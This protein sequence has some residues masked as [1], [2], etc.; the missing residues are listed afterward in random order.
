[1]EHRVVFAVLAEERH[2][3]TEVHVL[4]VICDKA[5]IAA[6]DTLAEFL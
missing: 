4:E 3:L 5:A 6:L 1:M 2:V